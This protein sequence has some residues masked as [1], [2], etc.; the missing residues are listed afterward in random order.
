[1]TRIQSSAARRFA[2]F[3]TL[4]IACGIVL[5]AIA[6]HAGEAWLRPAL[7]AG[8]V[9]LA[10]GLGL[11]ALNSAQGLRYCRWL[12]A[13]GALLFALSVLIGVSLGLRAQL[14]PVG[15][16]LMMLGWL[17][18]GVELLVTKSESNG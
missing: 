9:L 2:A 18:A 10:N 13:F 5:L 12:I 8:A 6:S 16:I 17:T 15:G 1:M 11:L 7:A 4:M 14:A 3:G